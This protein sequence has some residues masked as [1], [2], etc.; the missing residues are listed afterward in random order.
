ME[1]IFYIFYENYY[2]YIF[3]LICLYLLNFYIYFYIFILY[4]TKIQKSFLQKEI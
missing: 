1:L 3:I 4:L 2:T